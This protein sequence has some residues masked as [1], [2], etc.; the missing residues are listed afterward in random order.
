M[1]AAAAVGAQ[2]PEAAHKHGHLG[3][4]ETEQLGPVYQQVVSG[5]AHRCLL[6]VAEAIGLGLHHRKRGRIGV[7]LAGIH[8]A[9]CKRH[10]HGVARCSRRLLYAHATGQHDQIR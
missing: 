9:R 8:P 3:G 6:P 10:L 2:H 7:L 4:T 5:H 1:A